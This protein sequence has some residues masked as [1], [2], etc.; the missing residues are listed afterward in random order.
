MI[1]G[2]IITQRY[3]GHIFLMSVYIDYVS[4]SLVTPNAHTEVRVASNILD[5][6]W[7]TIEFIPRMG[8]LYLLID[9]RETT[10]ANSTYNNIILTDAPNNDASILI[11]GT[12]YS[13][14]MLHGPG[15]NFSSS[16]PSVHSIPFGPCPLPLGSCSED[17]VHAPMPIDYCLH[18]P[19][20]Q[21]G[22][23]ISK[24]DTYEVIIINKLI[25]QL[26]MCT[27][28][29]YKR[30]ITKNVSSKLHLSF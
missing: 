16:V 27:M 26:E 6:R 21:K 24:S 30:N 8:S 4:I 7:H 29:K 9:R 17:D 5:N 11:L 10:I 18:D 23:C 12:T 13:G 22:K 14:C 25:N 2:E 3:A 15:L 19:C 20:M 28:Y 1:G